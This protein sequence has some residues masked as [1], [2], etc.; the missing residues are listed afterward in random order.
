[1]KLNSYL[2]INLKFSQNSPLYIVSLLTQTENISQLQE[3]IIN[4]E[5]KIH[6]SISKFYN[7]FPINIFPK[8]IKKII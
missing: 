3:T 8:T 2:T 4:S 7:L 6:I 5:R 1:M